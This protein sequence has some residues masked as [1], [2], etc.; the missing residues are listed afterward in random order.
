MTK[1]KQ[2]IQTVAKN[3]YKKHE[4]IREWSAFILF[5]IILKVAAMVFSIFA[6]YFYFNQL[7][8]S[9]LNSV[10]WAKVFSVIALILIEVL[11]AISLTKFF[12]FALRLE[13]KAL[14]PF[15]LAVVFFG[16]SFYS[17]TNGLALRQSKKV[18]N[19]ENI[20]SLNQLTNDNIN[21]RSVN[22]KEEIK[23]QIKT[24]KAN[25]QGWH[26]GR[27]SVLLAA[28]LNK[29]DFYYTELNKLEKTRKKDLNNQKTSYL[30]A[31][32]ENNMHQAN[33]SEKYYKI[34]SFI[35]LLIFLVNGLLVYFYSKVN[36]ENNPEDGIKESVT[37]QMQKIVS[38]TDNVI[39]GNLSKRIYLMENVMNELTPQP[40]AEL[41]EK[42]QF[43][44]GFHPV[45]KPPEPVSYPESVDETAWYK[46]IEFLKKHK[47]LVKTIKTIKKTD[48]GHISN[49][50]IKTVQNISLADQKSR[51]LIKQVYQAA[52]I[53]GLDNINNNGSVE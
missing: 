25:K 27:R 8:I 33:E 44:I 26:N 30:I 34:V 43:K 7:F 29:I 19:T 24:I 5:T 13:L 36:S 46:N 20:T 37:D 50:E 51:S 11:V 39:F 52:V 41:P 9:I 23:E 10:F 42:D 49:A 12:K 48:F 3:S 21:T 6:G 45:S 47:E 53:I 22:I 15:V 2:L 31:L 35:M 17:S 1:L 40:V 32:N 28:Q 4:F 18:D 38:L 14:F 16:I